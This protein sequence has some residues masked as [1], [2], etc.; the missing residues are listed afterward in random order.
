MSLRVFETDPDAKPRKRDSY[1]ADIT[2]NLKSG[3]QENNTPRA[4]DEWGFTTDDPAVIKTLAKMYGGEIEEL[5]VEKG[6]DLRVLSETKTLDVLVA[7]AGAL[8][9]KMIL[10]GIGGPIHVCDGVYFLEGEDK[11]Q[12]CGCPS[13][14]ADRK[15]LAKKR[16]GPSP[17]IEL[18]FL[19]ADNPELGFGR[20]RTGSWSLVNDLPDIEDALTEHAEKADGAP[21]LVR[22]TLERV[23]YTTKMGRDV[24]YVRPVIDVVGPAAK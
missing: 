3:I 24:S 11:G 4:L 10:F 20:F 21:I 9:S 18:K 6:D 12:E 8:R 14:M 13:S 16:R 17:S 19:L 22:L 5:D 7:D 15:A 23:E 1:G 2:F